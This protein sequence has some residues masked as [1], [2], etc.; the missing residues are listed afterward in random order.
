[1]L[2]RSPDND[3]VDKAVQA[4]DVHHASQD[5]LPAAAGVAQQGRQVGQVGLEQRVEEAV[6]RLGGHVVA[7]A[8]HPHA[9][10][11]ERGHE[12]QGALPQ[13]PRPH[14]EADEE[15]GLQRPLHIIATVRAVYILAL[16]VCR[17]FILFSL[18]GGLSRSL[19]EL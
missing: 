18:S 19:A 12:P 9:G 10:G 14:D 5:A 7:D 6:H 3:H 11:D 15:Q 4:V 8:V 16:Y 17:V 1:M 2:F 13:R